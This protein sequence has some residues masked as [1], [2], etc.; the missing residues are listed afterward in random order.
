MDYKLH[1]PWK[2]SNAIDI[3]FWSLHYWS[4]SL[5]TQH[6][7]NDSSSAPMI[8]YSWIFFSWS[9]IK[10]QV[11]KVHFQFLFFSYHEY[12]GLAFSCC[13]AIIVHLIFFN[14]FQSY[15]QSIAIFFL[16]NVHGRPQFSFCVGTRQH[17]IIIVVWQ[18]HTSRCP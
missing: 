13:A 7:T 10:M 5:V 6:T 2:L 11:L 1:E 9:F 16:S 18:S 4:P 15:R 12:C 17:R 3:G 14:W 8:H